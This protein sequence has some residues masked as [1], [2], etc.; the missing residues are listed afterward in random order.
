MSRKRTKKE[1][2]KKH[3]KTSLTRFEPPTDQSEFVKLSTAPRG[4]RRLL[5]VEELILFRYIIFLRIRPGSLSS[6]SP[7]CARNNCIIPSR[8]VKNIKTRLVCGI[9]LFYTSRL[10]TSTMEQ[11]FPRTT[12]RSSPVALSQG[13]LKRTKRVQ[14][15]RGLTRVYDVPFWYL[16]T[17]NMRAADQSVTLDFLVYL[18]SQVR[19]TK[20]L[21][22]HIQWACKGEYFSNIWVIYNTVFGKIDVTLLRVACFVWASEKRMRWIEMCERGSQ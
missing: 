7:S 12:R 8:H 21:H 2:E 19:V 15:W 6:R 17:F 1:K 11:T 22:V 13:V 10:Q 14:W 18:A 4:I 16:P 20:L 5:T 3:R 9:F